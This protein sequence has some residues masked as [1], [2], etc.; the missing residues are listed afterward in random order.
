MFTIS[1]KRMCSRLSSA[2]KLS[3]NRKI[4]RNANLRPRR[5]S[6]LIRRII[7]MSQNRRDFIKFVVAGS[8][9]AGCPIDR[10]LLAEPEGRAPTPIVEGDHF[11]I[12][13]ELRD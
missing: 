7:P 1:E 10:A 12:T 2:A 13:H 5:T 11:K 4:N 8:V 6:A 9:A 3:M